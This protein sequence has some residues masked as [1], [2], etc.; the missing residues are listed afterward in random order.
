MLSPAENCCEGIP[1]EMPL[2]SQRRG[3]G[4]WIVVADHWERSSEHDIKVMSYNNNIDNNNNVL[5]YDNR[6][7]RK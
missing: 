7:E 5:D 4:Y 2:P 1:R 3:W 6:F